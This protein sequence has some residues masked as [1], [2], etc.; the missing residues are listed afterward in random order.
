MNTTAWLHSLTPQQR[1]EQRIWKTKSGEFWLVEK[2][3]GLH[4]LNVLGYL[5]GRLTGVQA[6]RPSEDP[7]DEVSGLIN[8][9]NRAEA[10]KRIQ[11]WIDVFQ[12]EWLSRGGFPA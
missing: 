4:I 8:E 9:D 7:F 2:M 1:L 11:A 10:V 6:Y 12:R 5:N 3:E